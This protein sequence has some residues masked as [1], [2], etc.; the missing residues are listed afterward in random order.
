M[1]PG[2]GDR[3]LGCIRTFRA[4]LPLFLLSLSSLSLLSL[5]LSLSRALSVSPSPVTARRR[6]PEDSRRRSRRFRASKRERQARR[7]LNPKLPGT[8]RPCLPES[9]R[10]LYG[11]SEAAQLWPWDKESHFLRFLMFWAFFF[12]FVCASTTMCTRHTRTRSRRPQEAIPVAPR[13]RLGG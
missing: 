7:A 2:A 13:R 9:L 10:A 6:Q 4:S 1:P 11:A 3:E 5:S 12:H 8:C